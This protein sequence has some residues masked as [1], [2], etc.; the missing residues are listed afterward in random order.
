TNRGIG[1]LQVDELRALRARLALPED[2]DAVFEIA[3]SPLATSS[4][5]MMPCLASA[6]LTLSPDCAPSVMRPDAASETEFY[7]TPASL[8]N[9]AC[10]T[11][12]S[13]IAA[14]SCVICFL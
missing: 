11:F 13:K 10:V 9:C 1:E 8:A 2:R 4:G 5:T 7:V 3:H 6:A 12:A 14:R